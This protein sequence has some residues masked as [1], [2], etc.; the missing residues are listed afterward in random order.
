[1]GDPHP[2]SV[3]LRRL[4]PLIAVVGLL[5]PGAAQG[6]E[7]APDRPPAST[8]LAPDP[9]PVEHSVRAPLAVTPLIVEPPR[10]DPDRPA[11]RRSTKAIAE[12]QASPAR[13]GP[14]RRPTRDA[15]RRRRCR[16][17][18]PSSRARRA[19]RLAPRRL[20]TRP[21]RRRA[22]RRR[23]GSGDGDDA[24]A[25]GTE[26]DR[27]ARRRRRPR[28]R[29]RS[30]PGR[31]RRQD[32]LHDHQRHPRR[33][34]LVPF[35]GPGADHRVAADHQPDIIELRVEQSLS[36]APGG[37][38]HDVAPAVQHRLVRA[39][40]HR[41]FCRPC[42]GQVRLVHAPGQ[43]SFQG[44][45]STSGSRRARRRRI[46]V[47]DGRQVRRTGTC[48]DKAGNVTA[49]LPLRSSTTPLHQP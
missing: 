47:P 32:R 34:R 17:R 24:D 42:I 3:H 14:S 7:P 40:R 12:A 45:D 6:G 31:G 29:A 19:T 44:T 26:C 10:P 11:A 8:A 21:R 39:L 18:R 27:E 49:R 41:R 15:D 4:L 43:L 35:G 36:I 20:E 9:A 48:R 37:A 30:R 16:A 13:S 2:A 25:D 28:L 33:Q 5:A 22:A 1:M 23:R 46:P 38:E